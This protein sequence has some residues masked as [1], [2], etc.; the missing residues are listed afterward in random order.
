MSQLVDLIA[1]RW[2]KWCTAQTPEEADK[3]HI[4]QRRHANV[5]V[6]R[7]KIYS[8]G[9]W[10]MARIVRERKT[11]K[12]LYFLLNGDRYSQTTSAQQSAVRQAVIQTGVPSVIIPYSALDSAGIVRDS[13]AIVD[14]SE[15]TF[16]K[17]IVHYDGE[18]EPKE[19][20]RWRKTANGYERDRW[21]HHLGESLIRARVSGR[22]RPAYFLSGF[23]ENETR[24]ERAYFL[25]ELPRNAKPKTITEAREALKPAPVLLAE[26]AGRAVQRQGDIF[27]VPVPSITTRTLTKAHAM[28]TKAA[29]ILGTNHRATEV[30][31]LHGVTYA[32][33]TLTHAPQDRRPDHRRVTIG[34]GWHIVLKNTVPVAA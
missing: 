26:Q 18:G 13:I 3:I 9:W 32:R 6:E 7:G 25:A 5:T 1:T 34:K 10:E 31:T 14:R 22:K 15:D 30:A 8:Y 11:H 23:D 28:R 20:Y 17:A 29:Y 24:P 27:A 19:P 4:P 33:G 16:T 21:D 2:A 12:P